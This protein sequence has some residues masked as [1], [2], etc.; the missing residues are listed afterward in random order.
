MK[1]KK[2]HKILIAV[3]AALAILAITA[4][5][6]REFIS[7][8]FVRLNLSDIVEPGSDSRVL[9]FA[10]HNDDEVLGAADLISKTVK[11]GGSVKVVLITNGDG[12]RNA[13][14]FD[15]L[16]LNPKPKDYIN[17]GYNRQQETLKALEQC[18]LT[19]K[20]VIFLGYP[21]GGVSSMWSL[22]WDDS[23]PYISSFTH[24]S[25][26]PYKNS[27]TMNAPFSGE[28][29]ASDIKSIILSY[30]PTHIVYPHPNDR[31]P[32]HWATNAFV[33]YVLA[34]TGYKPSYEWLYLVHRG[35]WPTPLRKSTNMYLVPPAKLVGTGTKWYALGMDSD[36]VA[37][38]TKAISSYKTQMLTLKPL[39]T[40][41]ERRNEMF[42]IYDNCKIAKTGK[43]D[44]DIQA[45]DY[46]RVIE[47]PLQDALRLE[48]TRG[49]DISAVYCESSVDGNLNVF[50]ETDGKIEKLTTYRL[51]MIIIDGE[52]TKRLNLAVK[53]KTL[54]ANKVSADSITDISSIKHETNGRYIRFTIPDKLLGSSKHIFINA[55]TSLEDHMLDKTAWRM[56]D[57]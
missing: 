23:F 53:G 31:H 39:L 45:A 8:Y 32:D 44:S 3:A 43:P 29:L 9:I 27:Y 55:M 40:A 51:N 35:D 2:I 28:S 54:T 33:K 24:T 19:E 50:L 12:Y 4:F 14:T 11:N 13:I 36:D 18:G 25:K 17:F 16:N 15:Y 57:N 30:K 20:D 6:L 56:L 42:G 52:N 38:K 41:F 21:D 46:N 10:P 1:L 5:F 34:T 37:Q 48:I 26:S 49:S 22:H 7:N 47:D